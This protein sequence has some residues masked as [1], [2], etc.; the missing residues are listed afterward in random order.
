MSRQGFVF[1]NDAFTAK[2]ID[3]I[4]VRI[5]IENLFRLMEEMQKSATI[6]QQTGGVHNAA[7]CDLNGMI[8]NRMD[9]GRHNALDKIYGYCLKNNLSIKDKMIVFSGRISSE[10][11]L[12]VAKIGCEIVPIQVANRTCPP[13]GRTTR[14]YN[15]WIYPEPVLKCVYV[16]V[17]LCK[18]CKRCSEAS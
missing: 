5:S 16:C 13:I 9:I 2:K 17:V 4:R 11:L 10:I 1:V 14:H 6:F 18:K 15:H 8:L 12:K 7:L 3:G